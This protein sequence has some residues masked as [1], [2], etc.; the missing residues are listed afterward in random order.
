MKGAELDLLASDQLKYLEPFPNVFARVSPENKLQI[1]QALQER[2]E[3]VAMT[4]D[5]VNDAPA[6][7]AAN[8]GIAM[9]ITGTEIT[10][11]AADVVLANDNFTTIVAAVEEGRRV[12]DNIQKFVLYLLS[13]NFAEI[14]VV[15]IAVAVGVDPPF[16]PMMILFAN[17]IADVPPSMS[18]GMEPAEVDIMVRPPRDPSRG[19]LTKVAIC[20]IVCQASVMAAVSLGA[21]FWQLAIDGDPLT[22]LAPTPNR[23]A[24]TLT[25]MLLTVMQLYQAFLSRS[26]ETSVFRTGILANRWMV[27][28]FIFSFV[29]MIMAVF[30]P[31]EKER[32]IS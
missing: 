7:K 3:S 17:I 31:G 12:F 1:V 14:L 32:R 15:L 13:C 27:A 25:F 26:I 4:G 22:D 5:G 20:F 2:G 30:I 9:G 16:T 29:F 24:Q 6:I 21:Y 28:A 18:L 23:H 19:V 10:K 11:Q 8:V